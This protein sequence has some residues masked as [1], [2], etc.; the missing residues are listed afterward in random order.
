MIENY[1]QQ[2]DFISASYF[3]KATILFNSIIFFNHSVTACYTLRDERQVLALKN[4]KLSLNKSLV[5][6]NIEELER[7]ILFKH[8]P[9]MCFFSLVSAFEDY[10]IEIS[11]LVLSKYP[12]KM[13]K[14]TVDFKLVLELT[15]GEL[16]EIK[17]KDYLNKIMYK[18]PRDY[19]VSICELLGI[20][21]D[22]IKDDFYKYI[23][24]KARRDLGIHNQWM[25]NDIYIRKL[26]EIGVK[27]DDDFYMAPD[28]D[29][30]R[31]AF[32]ICG[33]LVKNITNEISI[34]VFKSGVIVSA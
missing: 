30:F 1:S 14:E 25:K 20:S 7:D 24:I 5:K 9:S 11:M 13:A 31:M 4:L 3:N 15:K 28:L 26:D 10:L 16:L 27:S 6:L 8:M 21:S 29:Y 18:K 19:M 12:Q 32:D 2:L 33:S 23:E 17:S 22:E 34:K